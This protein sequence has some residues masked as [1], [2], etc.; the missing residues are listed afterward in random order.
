MGQVVL[1]ENLRFHKE[2]TNNDPDFA[3]EIGELW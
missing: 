3:K 2:E 1:L